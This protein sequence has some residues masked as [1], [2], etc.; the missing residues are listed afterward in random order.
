MRSRI[1][2]VVLLA[3]LLLSCGKEDQPVKG[4]ESPVKES[5]IKILSENPLEIP[6]QGGKCQVMYEIQ[7]PMDGMTVEAECQAEW[8]YEIDCSVAGTIMLWAEKNE[9]YEERTSR[10]TVTYGTQT[11]YVDLHQEAGSPDVMM[12]ATQLYG[13]YYGDRLH[14]GTASYWFFLSEDGITENGGLVPNKK[15]YRIDAYGPVIR[16]GS[17]LVIPQGTYRLNPDLSFENFTFTSFESIYL[18][19][20]ASGEVKDDIGYQ[21]DE[22]SLVVSGSTI[23]LDAVID[24]K[25]HKVVYEGSLELLDFRDPG[26]GSTLMDDYV[27]DLTDA[28]MELSC[29]FDYWECDYCNYWIEFIPNGGEGDSFIIDFITDERISENET[30]GDV[31]GTYGV[32]I[33]PEVGFPDFQPDTFIAGFEI[34]VSQWSGSQFMKY[35]DY[36]YYTMVEHA[37]LVDG[38]VEV[39]VHEDKTVTVRIDCY[40]DAPEPNRI[41]GEWTGA[42]K[43]KQRPS[44]PHY[45][46]KARSA[47]FRTRKY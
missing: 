37:P 39:I 28:R 19:T 45:S 17:P 6:G 42:P 2:I 47:R 43:I 34:A 46:P 4:D 13:H 7:N 11:Q 16:E 8:I 32:T 14:P 27:A 33:I 20:D 25:K 29:F 18:E 24:G 35:S 9:E 38:S 10:M 30:F 15:I 5:V 23:T 36:S 1:F 21:F 22:A 40:D 31:A 3:G 12:N 26:Y 44:V 41:T